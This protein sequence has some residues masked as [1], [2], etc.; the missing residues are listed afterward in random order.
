LS[1]KNKS[2]GLQK[3]AEKLKAKLHECNKY[4][5]DL[6]TKDEVQTLMNELTKAKSEN[7][8]LKK[9]LAELEAKISRAKAFVKDKVKENVI[10]HRKDHTLF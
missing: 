2:A 8:D 10:Q 1:E 9:N 3:E 6:A 7:Q 4:I 5:E